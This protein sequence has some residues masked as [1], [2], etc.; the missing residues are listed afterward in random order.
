[1]YV[2]SHIHL[3]SCFNLDELLDSAVDN[4]LRAGAERHGRKPVGCLVLTETARDYVYAAI[5]RGDERWRPR[6]WSV[7]ATDDDAAIVLRSPTNDEVIMLAGSQ[8]VT[9]ERLEVLALATTQRYP[10]GRPLRDTLAALAA[11]VVPAVIP[12]GFGKWWLGRGRLLAALLDSS[13]PRSFFLGDN[14]GRPIA[15]PRPKLF[16]NA[17]R[18]GFRIL[19]GTDL[20][21]Y[22]SQQ[23]KAGSFGFVLDSWRVDRRP[24][25]EF[26][27]ELARLD[28]SPRAFGSRVNLFEFTWL[29]VAMNTRNRVQ[30]IG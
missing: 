6:R 1:M 4:F 19:P 30:R 11:D 24:A 20:F 7:R 18:R 29:Q 27:A 3:H 12:W 2:D 25:A 17:E 21:P 13:E 9:S 26:R 16:R 15:T 10:D 8:I 5:V 14:G 28:H 22:V 23:R